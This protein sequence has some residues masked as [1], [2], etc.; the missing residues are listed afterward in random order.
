MSLT[1][2]ESEVKTLAQPQEAVY[3]LLSNPRRLAAAKEH[4]ADVARQSSDTTAAG[5][6]WQQAQ[7]ML[8]GMETTDDSLSLDTPVG[9]VTLHV[10][11]R[12]TP[13]LVKYVADGGPLPLTLWLQL[14]P[15]EDGSL[16]RVTVG[17]DVSPFMKPLVAK[18]LQQAADKLADAIALFANKPLREGDEA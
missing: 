6:D 5:A 17:A 1:K 7:A 11:E 15:H 18:P 2:R 16:L 12:E 4:I 14:L 10:A 9:K 8:Q 3:E 13:K